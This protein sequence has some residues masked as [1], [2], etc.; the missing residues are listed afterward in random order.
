MICS[1]NG[2]WLWKMKLLMANPLHRITLEE[3]LAFLG[4]VSWPLTAVE[5]DHIWTM[6]IS[7]TNEAIT[8]RSNFITFSA[9]SSNSCQNL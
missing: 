1:S 9:S 3:T 5:D 2:G 7:I 8:W 4:E 6:L